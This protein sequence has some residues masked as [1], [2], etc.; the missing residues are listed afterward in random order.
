MISSR[1]FVERTIRH[2]D[3]AAGLY[4]VMKRSDDTEDVSSSTTFD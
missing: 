2:A 4:I 3:E 1:D